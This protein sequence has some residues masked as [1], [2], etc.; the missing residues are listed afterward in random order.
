[1]AT[2]EFSCR[3]CGTFDLRMPMGSAPG[4]TACP[5]CGDAARRVYSAP[6]M[7]R[8]SPTIR[9]LRDLEEKSREAPDVVTEVPP[10]RTSRP[11]PPPN[12]ALRRLPRP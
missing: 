12:P 2:Y 5:D 3:S 6:R 9:S 10:R 1:M 7:R 11:A 4:V 8:L